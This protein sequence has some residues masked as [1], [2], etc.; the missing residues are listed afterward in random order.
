MSEEE[1]KVEAA[2]EDTG[3]VETENTTEVEA[4]PQKKR[5]K[6]PIVLGVVLVV[7]IAAGAGFWVWHEQP[8]F[9]AAICHT[10]MDEYLVTYDQEPNSQGVDKWGNE[11]SNTN[12][13]MVV[14]HKSDDIDCLGCHV[15]TLS[16]QIGEG[17]AWVTG[18][19]EYPL[20]E[21]S[22]KDL[23]EAREQKSDDFCLVEGCHKD[24]NGNDLNTREQLKETTAHLEFNPH[25]GQHGDEAC[26]SCHKAHRA[27]VMYCTQCHSNAEVPEG[28]LTTTEAN[29]LPMGTA[30]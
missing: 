4:A 22:L 16:E 29:Q 28:W 17:I 27:S 8:S 24:S 7:V 21:R 9:C 3:A 26:D 6:W 14:S 18:N 13:M 11:V 15:P 20:S 25:S 2:A 19:Y 10:P 23:G 1:T 5:K 12:S 30:A